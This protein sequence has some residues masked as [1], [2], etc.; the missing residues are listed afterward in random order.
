MSTNPKS[1]LLSQLRVILVDLKEAW[2]RIETEVP[3]L[4]TTAEITAYGTLVRIGI[5]LESTPEENTGKTL[6]EAL[7]VDT[8]AR[9]NELCELWRLNEDGSLYFPSEAYQLK[10]SVKLIPTIISGVEVKYGASIVSQM[11]KSPGTNGIAPITA[12]ASYL[13]GTTAKAIKFC[14]YLI[15]EMESAPF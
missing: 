15:K 6:I 2:P 3:P 11:V 9:L 12:V 4:L 5:C 8:L 7:I 10:A 14:E 1:S 13:P